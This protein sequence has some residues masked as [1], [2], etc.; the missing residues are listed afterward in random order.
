MQS[1]NILAHRGYWDES[2]PKNSLEAFER[3]LQLGFGIETDFRDLDGSLVVSHDPAKASNFIDASM[4]FALVKDYKNEGR[5]ALNIK[6]DGLQDLLQSEIKKDHYFELKS[7][8][9]DMSIPDA[10]IYAKKQI[11]FYGRISDIEPDL[12]LKKHIRGVWVDNFFGQYDQIGISHKLLKE[13]YR[14]CLVSPELHG[15]DHSETW[16]SIKSMKLCESPSFELCTDFPETALEFF[17]GRD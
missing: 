2:H 4:F 9:F 12:T 16:S 10:V 11:P 14:V 17:S 5:L 7:F 1:Q 3:A 8:A 13:G 6:A 15:R